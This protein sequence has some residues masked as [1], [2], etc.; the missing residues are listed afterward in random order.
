MKGGAIPRPSCEVSVDARAILEIKQYGFKIDA[1]FLSAMAEI[2]YC[3]MP[4]MNIVWIDGKKDPITKKEAEPKIFLYDELNFGLAMESKNG[5]T[6]V[7]IK[8]VEHKNVW[9][10][11][12]EIKE[13]SIIATEG[14]LK[15]QHFEPKPNI[16]FNNIGVYPNI[17]NGSP[18]LLAEH[19]FMISAFRITEIPVVYKGQVV[20]RPM[21]NVKITFDHRPLDGKD[22][23]KFLGLLKA[24][25]ENFT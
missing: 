3:K 24:K 15:T 16:I 5:L 7:T 17:V 6:V 23:A 11:N 2:V 8:D 22:P 1:I 4:Q 25:I 19:T 12:A 20:I 18:A 13:L 9:Q 14:K 10:L 21:M